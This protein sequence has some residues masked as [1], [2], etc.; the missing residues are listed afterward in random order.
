VNKKIIKII[1]SVVLLI[2]LASGL[3]VTAD[4]FELFGST[5]EKRLSFAEVRFRTI[6][7]ETGGI[8][9]DAQVRCF[10]KNTMNA[11][12]RKDSHQVGVVSVNVPIQR[13]V[14]KT[15]FF[16]KA[17]EIYKSIDPNMNI[18]IIHND[19]HNP[20]ITIP[21]EELYK[22]AVAEKT[23]KMDRWYWENES[24]ED[25]ETNE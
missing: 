9:M 16:N 19:Y 2:S 21:M 18:M 24:E 5:I 6:D 12:T 15:Y 22:T 7:K 23:V 17:E 25:I 14:K 20:T 4:Y 13:A 8:I 11:C 10:Q 1:V 3:F